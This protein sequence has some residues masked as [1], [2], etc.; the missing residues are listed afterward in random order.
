MSTG[1]DAP[2][3]ILTATAADI[4][5]IDALQKKHSLQLGFLPRPAIEWYADAGCIRLATD[6]AD[7]V[8]YVLSRPLLKWCPLIRPIIQAAV[9]MDAR[10]RE[11]GTNL[12][13]SV[14]DAAQAA[15]QLAVQAS[16]VEGND[17]NEF[18]RALGFIAI[19]RRAPLNQRKREIIV[20]RK[21][22]TRGKFPAILAEMPHRSGWKAA[23]QTRADGR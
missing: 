5:Y 2:T 6:N 7:P 1:T 16:C 10:N 21:I 19:G 18:W 3:T 14:V 20:W 11:H 13:Q 9:Q 15:G 4:R 22:L 8:G 12:V 17:A 23:K